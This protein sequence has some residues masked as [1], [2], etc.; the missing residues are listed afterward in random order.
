MK[1]KRLFIFFLVIIL[2]SIFSVIYP[3]LT[4]HVIKSEEYTKE[5]AILLRVIDG[6]TIE[7]LLNNEKTSIRMLGINT[8]EKKMPFSGEGKNFL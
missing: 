3:K 4:G 8:P 1:S 2:I 6:D 7:V 5:E